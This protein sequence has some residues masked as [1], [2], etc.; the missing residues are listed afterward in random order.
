MTPH[1]LLIAALAALLAACGGGGD[2]APAPVGIALG[3]PMPGL[4]ADTY[5]A[6]ERG[7]DLFVRRFAQSEGH[8]PD[9]NTSSCRS[10]HGVPVPGG[11]SERYRDFIMAGRF[12]DNVLEGAF[13]NEQFVARNF[14]Y[15]RMRRE[16]VPT[17]ADVIASRNAPPMFGMGLL[18]RIP[19]L[20]IRRNEDENDVDID[21][22]S[23]RANL[24]GFRVGRF[25]FKAQTADLEGFVRGPLFNH[26]GITTDPLS[27]GGGAPQVV[28]PDDSNSDDDGVA[29][30]ELSRADLLDLLVFVRELAPPE[31]EAMDAEAQRGETIFTQV[32]CADCHI[33]NLVQVGTPVL[34]YSDL[35][36]HD[37]GAGLADGIEMKDA[38]GTEFRTP[39]LWGVRHHAPY[40]HDGR[41]DDLEQA[42]IAHGGEASV[43]L[44]LFNGLDAADRAAL[45][46]FLETR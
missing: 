29:D 25:G 26:M 33:P 15:E 17:D 24:D 19:A 39:P 46:R 3:D 9:F 12:V 4:S 35:L 13:E 23:G 22:I 45:I 40:M 6:F 30:P 32:R 20:D 16:P 28:A 42:I 21:G 18:E 11:S 14:S 1:R 7:R 34:A 44:A 36:L 43:S 8:G 38:T 10:C 2:A 41:A 31:P 37:M 5:A 27:A